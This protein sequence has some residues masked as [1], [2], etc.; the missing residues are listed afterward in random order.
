MLSEMEKLCEKRCAT[1]FDWLLCSVVVEGRN[2]QQIVHTYNPGAALTMYSCSLPTTG[3]GGGPVEQ[4]GAG[5]RKLRNR[6]LFEVRLKRG[7]V[8]AL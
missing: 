1:Y 5:G 7:F 6:V 4:K 8:C 3:L 2:Q